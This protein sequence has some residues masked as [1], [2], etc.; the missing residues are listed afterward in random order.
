M[1]SVAL[2]AFSEVKASQLI[3]PARAVMIPVSRN[4]EGKKSQLLRADKKG[5]SCLYRSEEPEPSYSRRYGG[6]GGEEVSGV[7]RGGWW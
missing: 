5:I 7:G 4:H 1:E 3:C 2:E 6:W